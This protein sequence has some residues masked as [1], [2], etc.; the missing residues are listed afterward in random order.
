[1][2]MSDR[3]ETIDRLKRLVKRLDDEGRY[4]D[5]NICFLALLELERDE[6]AVKTDSE[7]KV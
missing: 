4:T 3:A 6:D 2:V 1:M 7:K 5:S